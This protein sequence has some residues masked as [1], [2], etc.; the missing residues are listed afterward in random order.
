MTVVP[1]TI[2]NIPQNDATGA[3]GAIQWPNMANGDTGQ[4]FGLGRYSDRSVEVD[5]TFGVGGNVAIKGTTSETSYKILADPNGNDLNI[6]TAKIETVLDATRY[7]RPE[8]TA[9]DGTTSLTVTLF[10][11]G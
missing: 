2:V 4:P 1:Y 8:V 5:G 7:I 10:F 3:S 6:T 11:R 9:G